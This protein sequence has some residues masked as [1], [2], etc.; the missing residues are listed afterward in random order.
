M[1]CLVVHNGHRSTHHDLLSRSECANARTGGNSISRVD[2]RVLAALPRCRI[3]LR[4]CATQRRPNLRVR[5]H[6]S[7]LGKAVARRFA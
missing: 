6:G 1:D 7:F 5:T 4:S 2:Q 3:A